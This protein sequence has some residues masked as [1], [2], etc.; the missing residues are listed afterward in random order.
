[1]PDCEYPKLASDEIKAVKPIPVF[2]VYSAMNLDGFG[3]FGITKDGLYTL[4]NKLMLGP[5]R[6][7]WKSFSPLVL[8]INIQVFGIDSFDIDILSGEYRFMSEGNDAARSCANRMGT[9]H[10]N[11]YNIHSKADYINGHPTKWNQSKDNN[12]YVHKYIQNLLEK[13][14]VVDVKRVGNNWLAD[15]DIRESKLYLMI[16]RCAE[17]H[18]AFIKHPYP[19]KNYLVTQHNLRPRR[20]GKNGPLVFRA[21][22]LGEVEDALRKGRDCIFEDS[23][24]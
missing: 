24:V 18:D 10:P 19:I 5:S 6:D 23:C 20:F 2:R 11:G 7:W 9:W 15:S 22:Y 8:R 13:Y 17:D 1:M 14:P 21:C 4:K 12:Y 3:F 16:C